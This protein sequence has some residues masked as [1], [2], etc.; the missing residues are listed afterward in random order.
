MKKMLFMPLLAFVL[1]ACSPKYY[2]SIEVADFTE[3]VKS[4]F[5]IYPSGVNICETNYVPLSDIAV[6]FHV[7]DPTK[8]SEA[9]GIKTY[10]G[11]D[12]DTVIPDKNYMI[13]CL[14][15]EAQKYGADAIVGFSIS[16]ANRIYTA[17]GVAVKVK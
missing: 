1:A 9:K 2:E 6:N 4:G 12:Y 11:K 17:K 8:Y 7:G 13:K 15:N 10:K 3:Y 14:V 16:Y 5:Y